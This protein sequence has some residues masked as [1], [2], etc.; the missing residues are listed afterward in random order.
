MA[1]PSGAASLAQLGESLPGEAH[2]TCSYLDYNATTPVYPQVA[3]A[4]APFLF[5]HF[6]NPSCDHA[7]ARPCKQAVE[8]ARRH[9]AALLN[10]DADE[11]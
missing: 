4:M 5:Q 9:V 1:T 8:E 2:A 10:C 7:F 6:G 11:I 3:A